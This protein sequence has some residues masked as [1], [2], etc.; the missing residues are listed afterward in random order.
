MLQDLNKIIKYF[1]EVNSFEDM[2]RLPSL[3]LF[4]DHVCNMLNQLSKAIRN[5]EEAK[6]YSD[7][8]TFGFFCRRSN[9]ERLKCQYDTGNRIGKG[10]S[11]HIAPSNVPINFAYS[12]AAGLLAGN[13]CIVRVSS[14]DFPQIRIICSLLKEIDMTPEL[15]KYLAVISYAHDREITDYFSALCSLRVIWGGDET[16]R[17]IRKSL[18]PPRCTEITFADRYSICV[19]HA[20]NMLRIQDLND[21]IRAF[22]ND[23][24]LYDQN[25]CSSPR[26]VYWMGDKTDIEQARKLFWAALRR[27]LKDRYVTEPVTAIDKLMM[28]YKAAMELSDPTIE[29]TDNNVHCIMVKSLPDRLQDYACPGGSFIEY[30][31]DSLSDLVSVINSKFQTLTYIGLSGKELADWVIGHGLNGIDRIV[32]VGKA[33]D[34][35]LIWDGYNLID[36]MSR[37]VYYEGSKY[38]TI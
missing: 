36:C 11:F 32:P 20:G 28:D 2:S 33:A 17:I 15:R 8:V 35:S 29:K 19:I 31:S 9:I 13:S 1:M 22:Y 10:L 37:E 30:A 18:L 21:I 7:I 25:A 34:F 23:T 14:K 4:D 5:D 38:D 26:L 6:K 3:K 24:Y 27:Y 12:L 16:I